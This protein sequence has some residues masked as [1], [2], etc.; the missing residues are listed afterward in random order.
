[1]FGYEVLFRGVLLFAAASVASGWS[2]IAL[3]AVINA[4]AHLTKGPKET[5]MSLPSS[6][7]FGYVTLLTGSIWIPFVVHCL[8]AITTSYFS[9][10]AHP[11]MHY[12][13]R[14]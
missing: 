4:L 11:E 5:I 8:M 13:R 9:F 3:M 6:I 1:L 10:R 14:S 2:A 12:V 7:A